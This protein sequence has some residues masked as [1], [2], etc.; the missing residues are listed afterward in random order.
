MH[1]VGGVDKLQVI[2]LNLQ[3]FRFFLGLA[4]GGFRH[5][6][7]GGGLVPNRLR[8]FL[9]AQLFHG[10]DP[11]DIPGYLVAESLVLENDLQGADHLDIVKVHGD[12]ALHFRGQGDIE[13]VSLGQAPQDYPQ[14]LIGKF[15]ASF[16]LQF[17]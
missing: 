1:H 3:G 5:L 14:I 13:A 15:K 10:G 9:L 4:L 8:L 12:L 2:D 17:F 11:E 7:L 16:L 6:G